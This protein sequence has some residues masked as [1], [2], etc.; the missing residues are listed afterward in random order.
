[1]DN[2]SKE[3]FKEIAATVLR[4]PK[5]RGDILSIFEWDMEIGAISEDDIKKNG[6]K[7]ILSPRESSFEKKSFIPIIFKLKDKV[8]I[9][10]IDYKI[11]QTTTNTIAGE[12][13][14]IKDKDTF[15]FNFDNFKY[16]CNVNY[17]VKCNFILSSGKNFPYIFNYK[18]FDN[19]AMEFIDTQTKKY[20]IAEQ[21]DFSK[22]IIKASVLGEFQLYT[23][24]NNL[25]IKLGFYL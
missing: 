13:S 2:K 19:E 15:V 3:R 8:E 18:I 22:D 7:L 9:K 12:G 4:S 6:M 17:E 5:S 16:I 11:I 24:K 21:N 14:F 20:L 1:M 25:L 23:R 10:S